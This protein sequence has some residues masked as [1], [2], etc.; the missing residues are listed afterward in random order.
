VVRAVL[1]PDV[2]W[3]ASPA[4]GR[5]PALVLGLAVVGGVAAG[6]L[7]AL[8]TSRPDVVAAL[9]RG[10]SRTHS[11]RGS[12]TRSA[13]T[14]VQATLS[15]AL[16]IGA[17]LF[18]RSLHRVSTLDLGIDPEG[19]LLV[20]PAFE[21]GTPRARVAAFYAR[22]A[23]RLREL[24]EVEAVSPDAS[25]PFLGWMSVPLRVPGL[26]S[27]PRLPGGDPTVHVVDPDY[28]ALLR[29]RIV[30]GRALDGRDVAGAP[31]AVVVSETMARALW[32]GREPLGQC[33]VVNDDPD[34]PGEPPCAEVVGV[35]E[36]ARQ[37]RLV[38][39]EWMSY[40][41]AGA[42]RVVPGLPNGFLVRVRGRA[43]GRVP[44]LQ[45]ALLALDP[46]LRHAHVW[47]LRA[48]IDPQAR[49]WRLGASMFSLFGV[50]SLLVSAVGLYGVLAFG[51]AQR[52]FELGVRAALG[53]GS[54]RLVGAVLAEALRLVGS[55]IAL[56]TAL[57]V[58]AGGALAPLLFEVS[59][60]DPLVLGGVAATL[61]LTAVAAAWVP[62]W[63]ATRVDPAT[64]LRAE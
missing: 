61:L 27:I 41:V 23:E 47:E 17:G 57:A 31:R 33:L 5:V 21:P 9:R 54:G 2:F 49:P 52:R 10:A 59:P 38:E 32:P 11:G 34:V 1:L 56:G 7:P 53:A 37:F 6:L 46:A 22:A 25:P 58:A 44:G 15:V 45:K 64:A 51:V 24:P 48:L 50:L 35:A 36:N 26:D 63:R 14:V 55:G 16:L 3:E 29:L 20:N 4:G 40:Y 42:Q 12:R 43:A 28:F 13:L 18:V 39:G 62:S 30:R 19:V 60:R 8:Q